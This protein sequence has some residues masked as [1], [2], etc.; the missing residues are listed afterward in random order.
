MLNFAATRLTNIL[1]VD[2]RGGADLITASGLTSGMR[3]TGGAGGDT[4]AVTAAAA[5]TEQ[6]LDSFR[7]GTDRI[8]LRAL[9]VTYADL[10]FV[11]SGADRLVRIRLASGAVITLRLKG[12]SANPP[13]SD[14]LFA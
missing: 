9:G 14:F 13:A 2:G 1:Y 4:F 7:S 3:Y 5:G 6:V 12:A 8:D 11:P 10:T